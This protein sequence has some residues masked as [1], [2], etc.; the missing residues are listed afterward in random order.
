[1]TF[2][3]LVN[4]LDISLFSNSINTRFQYS[5]LVMATWY[6]SLYG[7]HYH[8]LPTT[9]R[10]H[11]PTTARVPTAP[12]LP[13]SPWLPTAPRLPTA[14]GLP[15]A[16]PGLRTASRISSTPRLPTATLST[17]TTGPRWLSQH[18]VRSTCLETLNVESCA[19]LDCILFKSYGKQEIVYQ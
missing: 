16:A 9:T 10:C 3:S 5:Q 2:K 19:V 12:R 13:T 6:S 17:T 14:T 4:L 15:T 18:A 8:F 7:R 11:P 1:M